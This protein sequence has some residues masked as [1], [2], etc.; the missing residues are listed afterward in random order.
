MKCPKCGQESRI[1]ESDKFCHECG[2]PLKAVVNDGKTRTFD[3]FYIDVN[4]GVMLV[5]GEEVNNVIAFSL[6]LKEGE[7]NLDIIYDN[8]YKAKTKI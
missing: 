4:T 7:Y 5:N 8:L 6:E 3:S 1:K 2:F